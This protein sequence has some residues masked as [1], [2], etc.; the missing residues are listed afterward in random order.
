MKPIIW[1]SVGIVA[2]LLM[3][4]GGLIGGVL[5]KPPGQVMCGSEVMTPG[6]TCEEK[7]KG[8]HT[9]YSYEEMK[10]KN[11]SDPVVGGV[12]GM[13][14]GLG[15]AGLGSVKLVQAV[16]RRRGGGPAPAAPAQQWAQFPPQQFQQPHQQYQPQPQYQPP[17]YQQPPQGPQYPPP[18]YPQQPPP[19]QQP[20]QSFGPQG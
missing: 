11:A 1:W 13:A 2:G 20:P 15:L 14:F 12:V 4:V 5:S 19:Y 9:T 18:Q 10:D 3:A 7:R 6:D 17:Q 8:S 16:R